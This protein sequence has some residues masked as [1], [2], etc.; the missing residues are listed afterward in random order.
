MATF[1]IDQYLQNRSAT[2]DKLAS[3]SAA[4][5]QKQQLLEGISSVPKESQEEAIPTLADRM[6]VDAQSTF[7]GIVNLGA[8]AISGTTRMAGDIA[9][10]PVN[11]LNAA[12]TSRISK[13][14][15]DAYARYKNNQATETDQKVLNEPV[16]LGG[17][18]ALAAFSDAEKS[19]KVSEKIRDA[20]DFSGL[21]DNNRREALSD[22]LRNAFYQTSPMIE[23]GST[24][25]KVEGVARLLYSA[26]AA[27]LS[28][29]G[30]IAEYAAENIPQ[31]FVGAAGK[32]GAA[33]LAASNVGYA[34]NEYQKGLKAYAEANNGALPPPEVREKMTL[35]A[36]S[37]A[38]AEHASDVVGISAGKILGGFG[39]TASE[40]ADGN[41]KAARTSLKQALK[42]TGKATGQAA[43]AEAPTEGYQ[44]YMEGQLQGKDATGAEIYEAAVIGGAAGASIAGKARGLHEAGRLL[45]QR[46]DGTPDVHADGLNTPAAKP[47]VEA[48]QKVEETG[49]VSALLDSSAP[50]YAPDR[51]VAALVGFAQKNPAKLSESLKKADSAIEQLKTRVEDYTAAVEGADTAEADTK[52]YTEL[53]AKIPE[54]HALRGQ[55]EERLKTIQGLVESRAENVKALGTAKAH[56]SA[57][58]EQYGHLQNLSAKTND[59][60]TSELDVGALVQEVAGSQAGADVSAQV[61]EIITK[62]M[63]NPASLGAKQA[64]ELADNT[65]NAL[66][67]EHRTTL[68]KYSEALT[69]IDA[70]KT[71]QDVHRDVL[72]GE[73]G[74]ENVGIETYMKRLGT[75]VRA[76]NRSS[77]RNA[78]DGITRFLAGH[79]SKV[80][81]YQEAW[82]N[83][84]GAGNKGLPVV[85]NDAGKWVVGYAGLD[86][87]AF[88]ARG[89]RIVNSRTLPQ[90]ISKEVAALKSAS[91]AMQM[92]FDQK[93]DKSSE[94]PAQ[95]AKTQSLDQAVE[96]YLAS[97]K[98]KSNVKN[99]SQPTSQPAS[100]PVAAP[101][102]AATQAGEQLAE[103]YG[104]GDAAPSTAVAEPAS[105]PT[106]EREQR[107]ADSK[108]LPR[109]EEERTAASRDAA[110]AHGLTSLIEEQFAKGKTA[111][112]ALKKVQHRMSFMPKAQW[113]GF[114]KDVRDSLGIPARDTA[115]GVAAFDK[116]V[117]DRADRVDQS[118]AKSS[119]DTS[120]IS[121]VAKSTEKTKATEKTE[122][123]Q[124]TEKSE[125]SGVDKSTEDT[126][127]EKS[128][129]SAQ[130][131]QPDETSSSDAADA[132]SSKQSSE[133]GLTALREG[134]KHNEQFAGKKLGDA[135]LKMNR[136]AA[137][138]TQRKSPT[139]SGGD[140]SLVRPLVDIKDLA[141]QIADG[142]IGVTDLTTEVPDTPEQGVAQAVALKTFF[143]TAAQ[144][145]KKIRANFVK[146]IKTK[147]T[148]HKRD[149]IQEFINADGTVDENV[150]TAIAYG[151]YAWLNDSAGTKRHTKEQVLA[152]NGFRKDEANITTDGYNTLQQ[153][154]ALKDTAINTMGQY[155]V[156]ALGLKASKD[157]S[158]NYM[159]TLTAALGMHSLRSLIDQ[160]IVQSDNFDEGQLSGW[161]DEM[162]AK[163]VGKTKDGKTNVYRQRHFIRVLRDQET[164]EPTNA[165]VTDILNA[166]KGTGGILDK[167]MTAEAPATYAQ[168]RP[169]AFK[170]EKAKRSTRS[171]AKK[172]ANTLHEAQQVGHTP[173][174]SMWD[175]AQV[176]GREVMLVAAGWKSA[177]GTSVHVENLNSVNAQ[178]EN[179]EGQYDS[180]VDLIARHGIT[181]PLYLAYDVWRNNRVGIKTRDLNP[182]SSKIHRFMFQRP[183]WASTINLDN[184]VQVRDYE[185]GLAQAFGMKIDT[186]AYSQ[187]QVDFW[188]MLTEEGSRVMELAIKLHAATNT[189]A[190]VE[191]SQ[192]DKVAV[193][194]LAAAREGMQTLQALV[195]LGQYLAAREDTSKRSFVTTLLVGVDG[196][197]N[198][199]ILTALLLGAADTISGMF[200][201][202]NRG[203]IYS[204]KQEQHNFNTWYGSGGQHDLYESLAASFIKLLG[205][206][207]T[208]KKPMRAV[209]VILKNLL[210]PNGDVASA[211]R[212]LSKTPLTSFFFG[213]SV[214]KSIANMRD[215]FVTAFIDRIEDIANGREK[216]PELPT[217]LAAANFVMQH[218]RG[219][220]PFDTKMSIQQAMA[221]ELTKGQRL[222]LKTGFDATLGSQVETAMEAEFKEFISRRDEINKANQLGYAM[223]AAV[224]KPLREAHMKSLMDSGDV[225]YRTRTTNAGESSQVPLHDMTVEQES[226]FYES[227]KEYLP[228]AHTAY[229][230]AEGNLD[231]GVLMAKSKRAG[232]EQEFNRVKTQ[233]GTAF[234]DEA[235][236]SKTQMTAESQV[237]QDADVGVAGL[238]WQIH[239]MDSAT[240]HESIDGTQTLNVHDEAGNAAEKV[241]DVASSI[242]KSLWNQSLNFSPFLASHEML[243]RLVVSVAKLHSEGRMSPETYKDV[244]EAFSKFFWGMKDAAGKSVKA[245]PP[246]LRIQRVLQLSK[247]RQVQADKLRL[248][249]LMYVTSIDQYTWE[250]G[251]YR[252][253][254]EDRA[255]AEEKLNALLAEGVELKAEVQDAIAVLSNYKAPTQE[256]QE[257]A[258][259]VQPEVEVPSIDTVFGP[260][261]TP[262]TKPAQ[263]WVDFFKSNPNRS[264]K[265]VIPVLYAAFKDNENAPNRAFSM[266]LIKAVNKLIS[267]DVQVRMITPDT[268]PASLTG[269]PM[270]NARGWSA[271]GKQGRKAEIYLLSP[272]FAA[273]GL[274]SELVLH[275]LVHAALSR[276]VASKSA[277]AKA[278]VKELDRILVAARKYVAD[279]NL[280]GFEPA[281]QDID[282]L[283]AWG[284]TNAKFQQQVLGKIEMQAEGKGKLTKALTKFISTVADLL[285][286]GE[287][288]DKTALGLFLA[289]SVSLMDV[290][291]NG[292]P[293]TS[294]NTME[295][296]DDVKTMAMAN[297]EGQ[298]IKAIEQYSTM[299]IYS[300]LGNTN[301]N[302]KVSSG[303]DAQLRGLVDGMVYKLHGAFGSLAEAAKKTEAGNP[304]AV[305]LKAL[306][307]GKAPFAASVVA[308]PLLSSA[309][310]DFVAEQ[311]QATVLAAI[312]GDTK[313][314]AYNELA[315]LYMEARAN[316]K[317]SDLDTDP[318]IGQQKYDFFFKMEA[319]A[320]KRSDYLARFA[321]LGL[322]NE[323]FNQA[324]KFA[325]A[326]NTKQPKT[327]LE[328]LSLWFDKI[329]GAL[330]AKVTGAQEGQQ[331]D[332]KL[333][334]LVDTLVGIEARK[335]HA[336]AR[337]AARTNTIAER[338]EQGAQDAV[339]NVKDK[340]VAFAGSQ[341]FDKH[342]NAFVR[343]AGKTVRLLG[344]DRGDAFMDQLGRLRDDHFDERDGVL[345]SLMREL[346]HPAEM[347]KKLLLIT[348]RNEQTRKEVISRTGKHLLD[349]Y[350]NN[351]EGL[352]EVAKSAISAVLLRSGAHNLLDDLSIDEIEQLIA[353]PV[354]M[355]A[356]VSALEDA[357]TGKNAGFMVRQA[358]DLGYFKAT[359]RNVSPLLMMNAY[360]IAKL[361]GVG[362]LHGAVPT[363]DAVVD[364]NIAV[365][366]KLIALYAIQYSKPDYKKALLQVMRTEAN[367]NDGNG[368]EFT[369]GLH[370]K[371]EQDSLERLFNGN[372]TQM[373]HGYL[374]DVVNPHVEVKVANDEEGQALLNQGYVKVGPVEGDPHDPLY[375]ERSLYVLKDGGLMPY[376]SGIMSLTSMQARGSELH[377][378]YL[379]KYKADGMENVTMNTEL[380]NER[381]LDV[382]VGRSQSKHY[383]PAATVVTYMAPIINEQGKITNWRYLMN[384]HTK[385]TVMQRDNRFENL[386]GVMAGSVFDKPVAKEQNKLAL[387]ALYEQ[388]KAEYSANPKRYLT[389]GPNSPDAELREIW[390]MLPYA[391]KQDIKRVWGG[392]SITI[393]K[394]ALDIVFGYRKVSA[395][396]PFRKANAERER[397]R[398]LGLP[399]DIKDLTSISTIQKVMVTA[400]ESMLA[401][402]YR[403][404]G[405]TPDEAEARAAKAAVL[406]GRAE[407]GWQ[408]L[409]REAKDII[410]VKS[411]IV[412][413]GNI[414]S[415]VSMLALYGVGVKDFLHNHKVALKGAI[416]Y[417]AD[418]NDLERLKM[419][420]DTGYV[421]GN[422]VDID[423]EIVRLED[424][425]AR[426]PVRSLIEAGLMPTI[427]EDVDAEE[428]IYSYK[429]YWTRKVNEQGEKVHPMAM[430]GARLAYMAHDTKMYQYL[431]Q[432]T[433]LSDFVARYT[434]VQHLTS[435]KVNP[436]SEADAIQRASDAFVN[437]DIPMHRA[438]QYSD[439]MGLTMF[440]KYFLRIQREL[441]RLTM[442]NPVRVL[443]TVLA[444]NFVNLGPIVLDSHWFGH[445]GNNPLGWGA[446]EFPRSLDQLATAATASNGLA[447]LK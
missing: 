159:G 188:G 118:P 42:N 70:L 18:T 124:L 3:L 77:A 158:A 269:S 37:L 105:Q 289:N 283:L 354:A 414:I 211:G 338:A 65:N 221:M 321:A 398:D 271:L 170:Q 345:A 232:G 270:A 62:A 379:N 195:S 434:L 227:I 298:G 145:S 278:A 258:Q 260:T 76:D 169:M 175:T 228:V 219:N 67:E 57:A 285:G 69:N 101:V 66:S 300:A 72:F 295:G 327:F 395:A 402:H 250:G 429:S 96:Q 239:A 432:T 202:L 2:N 114:I 332:E 265:E 441:M 190:N 99:V 194:E 360:N 411:G 34:A 24:A 191:M 71:S 328:R 20:A 121:D 384:E 248:G 208:E 388:Y 171:V 204:T 128:P 173:I 97:T 59:E 30:A 286:L 405:A 91:E 140:T 390:D 246:K 44:T 90:I 22:E 242:N 310:E 206:D 346:R 307:T 428:D 266:T 178:N 13:A 143:G 372:P 33:A 381:G 103:G 318:V 225:A 391:T 394:D 172:L 427:V 196:K 136:A 231:A 51:A 447:L 364:G 144:W 274:T 74:T 89:G 139:N 279:N 306:E 16:G 254:E 408:E 397:L 375:V 421:Q 415:N 163:P 329:L 396:T 52:K 75:A 183:E 111:A 424:A 197:T 86:A 233:F 387:E 49:D 179:L 304:L 112:Q 214:D 290:A 311:V 316:I 161:I 367:R 60:A 347:Y 134:R 276:A 322:A 244:Q 165:Q 220:E 280:K 98:E 116:W 446:G 296:V 426:N 19:G 45:A 255:Q 38:V 350:A 353:D 94:K 348:K 443:S 21:V 162:E 10:L 268:D 110:D 403:M 185:M 46:K 339:N 413:V 14:H 181:T 236:Q 120:G 113:P 386:V 216:S 142:N 64:L 132:A 35:Q 436:M 331:A 275:E 376:Q 199:P 257:A 380:F 237:T 352:T 313:N 54:G 272:E 17:S 141:K 324:L 207:G 249:A 262:K 152:M 314:L 129:E 435:R 83:G 312:D 58:N 36:A 168:T 315:K 230:Q 333:L 104:F 146:D 356:H 261:G 288:K 166:S 210:K 238:P 417:K 423:R 393:R 302:R 433:Q 301:G 5:Q 442:E 344:E 82:D 420:R 93:F 444:N 251:E 29:P 130:V 337:N 84:K 39:K 294:F 157:A 340:V 26:G 305:W 361:T 351:G 4:S 102:Q 385:D 325:T 11:V 362:S 180:M 355:T 150:V 68:R 409:V 425:L 138:L 253:T 156:A 186:K 107:V 201:I 320:D 282:E 349:G 32:A 73:G 40:V 7:G 85:R 370:K 252:V 308:S 127:Q 148:Y 445:V 241:R 147:E 193:G 264:V 41:L 430:K 416:S 247:E 1:D 217:L 368:V 155:V 336:L 164:L 419:L 126:T 406:V 401:L 222:A 243:E 234:L 378:G 335:R 431:S 218:G 291:S 334:V 371:L 50:T 418:K 125:M 439:D 263:L 109:V 48:V 12:Q 15:I 8:S 404:K 61:G 358:K 256:K 176:L 149:P 215:A 209:Q 392:E 293:T 6:G 342:K 198:G 100:V 177:S 319:G 184:E 192:E 341:F 440:T 154:A 284:L 299:E 167:V 47:V 135:F 79:Q 115:E 9:A 273:S 365:L 160:G 189:N 123:P 326:K 27:V 223:F 174:K 383:N 399:A 56:L 240:M 382:Q 317:P 377:S 389:I 422:A 303:F 277:Q 87:K 200:K 117:A 287:T 226:A 438:L 373:M 151:A 63:A 203:G 267:G 106:T 343:V 366:N 131:Q 330:T 410:V 357:I 31:L 374:P 359:G 53:L 363:S 323:Q 81:A 43:L 259:E 133:P 153:Y 23:D 369:L 407:R 212:A 182:Q 80:T 437:Y 297:T 245:P 229:S 400:I 309:Q 213:S 55:V 78:L 119:K 108:A 292:K 187:G 92:A 281:T 224:L 412:L 235:N 205:Q 95:A 25:Q 28:N 137:W 122:T 88:E